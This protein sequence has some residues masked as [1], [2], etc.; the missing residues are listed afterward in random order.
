MVLSKI[1]QW[2]AVSLATVAF[3]C[4]PACGGGGA[5]SSSTSTSPGAD[6]SVVSSYPVTDCVR[7][8]VTGLVW[9]GKTTSGLR[10]GSA[11]FT[12]YD[13]TVLPQ[14]L[15]GGSYVVAT[16]TLVDAPSNAAAYVKSVNAAALCG[17]TDWRLPTSAELK[18]LVQSKTVATLASI[19]A[20]WFPNTPAYL[21][22]TASAYSSDA[23]FAWV[24]D[25]F[26]GVVAVSAHRG[27]PSHLRL[28]R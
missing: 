12:H 2:T 19:D 21:Y 15:Q 26:D 25:F 1:P 28:V 27:T 8:N 6:Y 11:T 24:V 22:W 5:D 9:E 3:S 18:S 20:T 7:S 13:S 10:A 23:K 14:V 4:L 16:P 17:Y